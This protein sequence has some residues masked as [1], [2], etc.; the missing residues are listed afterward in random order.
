ME[1]EMNNLT[2]KFGDFTAVKQLNLSMTR[3]V[4]GLL[5]KNGAGK[6][7]FMRMLCTLLTPT[8]GN[9][10]CDGRDIFKMEGEYRKLLGYLP[11][12]FGFYPEFTVRDYLLYIAS[13]KGLPPAV[14]K[15]RTKELLAA[16]GLEKY[17]GRKMKK[18]SGG[19]KRRAGIA[20]AM[21]N[22]PKILIL[23]E[24]TAGLDPNER[25]RF[26]N[27]ISEFSEDR[28]VLLSTH[29]V[30]DVEYIANDIWLMNEGEIVRQGT[31]KQI[32]ESM[33]QK[34][35]ECLV[36]K[37]A[38]PLLARQYKISNMKADTQGVQVRVIAG[39]KPAEYAKEAVPSLED[40]FLYYFG[41]EAG[42]NHGIL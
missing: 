23:D 2:K 42:D 32:T 31:P 17:A 3:G 19:M 39:E 27:L 26:R 36:E 6:T 28:L 24:P 20:Q 15:K 25:I 37:R 10:L 22:H 41:E 4:Y 38:V 21:M 35:W 33:K 7:T 29:I 11:Q 18:L 12:D 14:A 13:I 9:I 16:V 34:V 30:S 5:G 8:E 40:A 1:L